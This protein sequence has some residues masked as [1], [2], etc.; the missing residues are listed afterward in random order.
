MVLCKVLWLNPQ[1]RLHYGV[2]Y[3]T[4]RIVSKTLPLDLAGS[5]LQVSTQPISVFKFLPYHVALNGVLPRFAMNVA[6]QLR[7]R[8]FFIYDSRNLPR[9]LLAVDCVPDDVLCGPI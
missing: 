4:G 2:F 3:L 1:P 5:L 8:Q 6:S 7:H 9:T